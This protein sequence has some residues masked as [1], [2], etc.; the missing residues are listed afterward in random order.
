MRKSTTPFRK[1]CS[2]K[3]T[4]TWG[5]RTCWTKAA[6]QEV[7]FTRTTKR[8]KIYWNRSARRYFRTC[9]R[10]YW[11]RKKPRL[12]PLVDFW[13]QAFHNAH[14]LSH[15]GRKPPNTRDFAFAKQGDFPWL[16]A[17]RRQGVCDRV[18]R[19][20]FRRPERIARKLKV[21]SVIESFIL[22]I[23]YWSDA[24]FSDTPEKLTDY[25]LKLNV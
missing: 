19:Q 15:K 3:T 20:R 22:I 11:K 14:F 12:F 9:F 18:R 16:Y 5:F 23:E 13:L 1:F 6:S 17:R 24:G 8:K 25:F 10:T 4:T 21:R 2:L 7:P